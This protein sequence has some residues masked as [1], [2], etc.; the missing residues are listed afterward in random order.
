MRTIKYLVLHCTATQ[1]SASVEAIKNYWKT[2][3]GWKNPGYHY[4][5]KR[6]GEIVQL[7]TEDKIANGVKGYNQHSIHISYIGGVDRDN[8]P[9]D[10]R[11]IEQE[12]AM[13]AKLVELTEKYPL[14]II[15]GHRDFP[16][17]IKACP[18]FDAKTWL[19]GYTPHFKQ[20]A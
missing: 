1:P 10:N 13:F 12:E 7:Q 14:A 6:S 17:V 16:G 19:R 4:L 8:K 20:A 9:K 18:S 3:L 2:A 15:K 11:T 5:I